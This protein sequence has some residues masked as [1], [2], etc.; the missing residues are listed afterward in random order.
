MAT[1]IRT[2]AT[3]TVRRTTRAFCQ[4]RSSRPRRG[5]GRGSSSIGMVDVSGSGTPASPTFS[6]AAG[7]ASGSLTTIYSSVR[8][9]SEGGSDDRRAAGQSEIRRMSKLLQHPRSSSEDSECGTPGR[10][11]SQMASRF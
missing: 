4:S 2:S 3:N 11:R 8:Q 10:G 9:A 7:V 1:Q 5:S 6:T